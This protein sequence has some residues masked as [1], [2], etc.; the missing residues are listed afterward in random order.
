MED[1]L[2][3][4]LCPAMLVLIDELATRA[5]REHLAEEHEFV[6]PSAEPPA[7]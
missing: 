6:D 5:V 3:A 1:R 7:P 2:K 4:T